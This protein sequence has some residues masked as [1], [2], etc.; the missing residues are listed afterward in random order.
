MAVC[1]SSLNISSTVFCLNTLVLFFGTRLY[2]PIL[3]FFLRDDN[4]PEIGPAAMKKKG[5]KKKK[6]RIFKR[7]PPPPKMLSNIKQILGSDNLDEVSLRLEEK[8]VKE[9]LVRPR[10]PFVLKLPYPVNFEV[11]GSEERTAARMSPCPA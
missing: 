6:K 4:P 1:C 10:G 11:N 9:P 7:K 8:S 5:E 2:V 3:L